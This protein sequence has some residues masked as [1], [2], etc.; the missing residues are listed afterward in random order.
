MIADRV[1]KWTL[2]AIL[3][4]VAVTFFG[5]CA[6][7]DVPEE[8]TQFW[9]FTI[10]A[11]GSLT[12]VLSHFGRFLITSV[13]ALVFLVHSIVGIRVINGLH[14]PRRG[15]IGTVILVEAIVIYFVLLLVECVLYPED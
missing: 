4:L 10:V 14:H 15:T 9:Y 1:R 11:F 3:I 5:A 13:W 6:V 2:A 12:R 8:R 7:L